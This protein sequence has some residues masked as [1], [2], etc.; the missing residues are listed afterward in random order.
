MIFRIHIQDLPTQNLVR[1]KYTGTEE[2]MKKKQNS[3]YAFFN[4]KFPDQK[5]V[6]L[7]PI[8]QKKIYDNIGRYKGT[9]PV[10]Q[11]IPEDWTFSY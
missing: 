10:S 9:V 11:E 5:R 4:K 7:I 6:V 1:T 8:T 2:Q 3:L